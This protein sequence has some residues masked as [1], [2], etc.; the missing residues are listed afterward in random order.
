MEI[1]AFILGVLA[2]VTWAV[3]VKTA[4]I[5]SVR[6]GLILLTAALMCQFVIQSTHHIVVH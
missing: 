3:D 1:I 4:R 5:D 2:I 6:L